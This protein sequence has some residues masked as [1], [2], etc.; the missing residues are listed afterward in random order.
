MVNIIVDAD[1]CP[2]NQIINEL[3]KKYNIETTYICDNSH[4][5]NNVEQRVIY[6]DKGSDSAD[7][8]ILELCNENSIII[9]QD[10]ALASLCLSKNAIVIHFNAFIIDNHNIDTLLN[11]RY[12]NAKAR[13][14][15]LKLSNPK[16]RKKEIDVEFK[17]LLEKTI[18]LKGEIL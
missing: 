9:T 7:Y 13:K 4:Q 11:T 15:K 8:K 14:A 5:I 12:L 6:V 16:K 3:S 10:Y 2:T 17:K 18:V 1:A